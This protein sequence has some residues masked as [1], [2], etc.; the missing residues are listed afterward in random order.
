MS[1]S[2]PGSARMRRDLH[3]H[4][5]LVERVVDRRDLALAEGVV[6]RVVDRG[7][8]Q[9][10]PRGGVAVD[11]EIDL[12]AVLLLVG[13]DVGQCRHV[14]Q[15]VGELRRPLV[16][17]RHV[18][19]LQRVLILGVAL[20]P[21]DADVLHRL[22]EQPRAGDL[23]QLRPQAGDHLVRGDLALGLRLSRRRR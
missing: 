3:H 20:A 4:V 10:Q 22:Q 7:G 6:E 11:G 13:V 1:F 14:L 2:V 17:L 16:E 18:S 15:R 21:A 23:V 8:I 9:L 12:Q 5:I 19:R